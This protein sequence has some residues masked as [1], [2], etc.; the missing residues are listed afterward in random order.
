[1]VELEEEQAQQEEEDDEQRPVEPRVSA[2]PRM[3]P[4]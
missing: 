3:M 4:E 2:Q 1:M